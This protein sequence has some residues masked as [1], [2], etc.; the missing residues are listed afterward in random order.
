[1]LVAQNLDVEVKHLWSNDFYIELRI[2]YENRG[3]E[4]WV[5]FVHSS[6]DAK[7]RQQQ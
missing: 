4:F 5:I 6:N 3:I 1:M 7:E 2:V